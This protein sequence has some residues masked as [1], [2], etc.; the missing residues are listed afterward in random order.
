MINWHHILGLFTIQDIG[1]QK[2][3]THSRPCWPQWSIYNPGSWSWW[4]A[5]TWRRWW[6]RR[7]S[8][9]VRPPPSPPLHSGCSGEMRGWQEITACR[10]NTTLYLLNLVPRFDLTMER[11]E[12]AF[13]NECYWPEM[14]GL[15]K[16]RYVLVTCFGYWFVKKL[17]FIY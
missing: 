7:R 2:S 11:L 8:R 3:M 5:G 1:F 15:R 16:Q 4:G 12:W 17:S 13:P 10:L 14:V 9:S 6:W